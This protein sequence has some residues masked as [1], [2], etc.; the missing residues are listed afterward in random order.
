MSQIPKKISETLLTL[1]LIMFTVLIIHLGY[2]CRNIFYLICEKNGNISG[3]L[4]KDILGTY[5]Q[6]KILV[7][8][9]PRLSKLT[10]SNKGVH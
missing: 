5:T 4:L 8:F 3:T 10:E 7:K 2:E 9:N 1:N 6:S